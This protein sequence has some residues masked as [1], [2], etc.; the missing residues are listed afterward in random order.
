M[1]RLIVKYGNPILTSRAAAVAE[2][3]ADVDTV[4][5]EMVEAMHAAPGIGLAA[6]QIGC[7]LRICIVDLSAGRRAEELRVLINPEFVE[8]ESTQLEE[9]GC[10]SLPGFTATVLRPKRVTIRALDRQGREHFV[11]GKELL[12]RALQHEIDHLDGTLFVDRLR[13]I[14]RRHII[15]QIQK[16]R[17][18]G[19]W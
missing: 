14:K 7:P 16:L 18:T 5:E 10:L 4:I 15:R 13:G 3:T 9:E 1:L 2:I 8:R 6:P 11:E 12:A 19:R 17:R